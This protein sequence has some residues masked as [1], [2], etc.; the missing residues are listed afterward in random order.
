[1]KKHWEKKLQIGREA[2]LGSSV[3]S[4]KA[5]RN[6]CPV[7]C[8]QYLP[9]SQ[10]QQNKTKKAANKNNLQ[11]TTKQNKNTEKRKKKKPT[12]YF[13]QIPDM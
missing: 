5:C 9:V 12:L 2:G 7:L 4:A 1:M 3:E 10:E 8:V 11:T 6:A 13:N